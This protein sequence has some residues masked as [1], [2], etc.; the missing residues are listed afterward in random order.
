MQRHSLLL[1]WLTGLLLLGVMVFFQA[2][3][4][5]AAAIPNRPTANFYDQ[6]NVLDQQTK[7]LVSQK[8]ISYDQTKQ[9]PQIMLA[10]IKSTDGDSIDSYA[11][12]LFSNWGL[13]QRQ[14]DNGVLILY[15][16]N[17]GQRNVRIEVGYGLES[18]LTDALSG[19]ILQQAKADLKSSDPTRINRGLR[20]VFNSVAT[21]IDKKYDFKADKNTLSNEEYQQI[22]GKDDSSWSDN[23]GAIIVIVIL[24]LLFM[25]GGSGRGGGR[26]WWLWALLGSSSNRNNHWGG[27]SGGFGGGDSGGFGGFSGG[28]GSSGGGGASI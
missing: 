14:R 22:K 16:L 13:G 18:D 8:N 20:K 19:R 10:V 11:P 28:G 25:G 26:R 2:T 1:S 27:G 12:D 6:I 4:P 23:I 9:R 15:A 7:Q 21:V 5:V 24:V 17:N 3:Q